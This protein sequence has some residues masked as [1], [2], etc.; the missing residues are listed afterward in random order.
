MTAINFCGSSAIAEFE[1]RKDQKKRGDHFVA[2]DKVTMSTLFDELI[3]ENER[4]GLTKGS[5]DHVK[6]V[7]NANLRPRW[8]NYKVSYFT[9]VDGM[10]ETQQWFDEQA[11]GEYD[12]AS[13]TL[14]GFRS[15]LNL[16]FGLARNKLKCI[17]HNPLND[18]PLTVHQKPKDGG[19]VLGLQD[20]SAFVSGAL[21]KHKEDRHL[22]TWRTRGLVGLFGLL[23]GMRNEE[24]AGLF[25][26]CLN[27]DDRE[28]YVRRIYREDEGILE[29]TKT[30]KSGYRTIPMSPILVP[31]ILSWKECLE[32]FGM[33]LEGPVLRT[34]QTKKFV[35][36][37][38]IGA[39]HWPVLAKKA[40][41][42]DVTGAHAFTYYDL[43][44][45]FATMLRTVGVDTDDLQQVMGHAD[46][47]TTVENYLHKSPH[48]FPGLK[49]QVEQVIRQLD[50]ERTAEGYIDALGFVLARRWKDE[51]IDEVRCAPPRSKV[52]ELAAGNIALL[53]EPVL[54]LASITETPAPSS[55]P[56]LPKTVQE[57]REIQKQEMCARL[58]EGWEID[59]VSK[60]YGVD[61][62]TVGFYY[63]NRGIPDPRGKLRQQLH[64][65]L[66]AKVLAYHDENPE[67]PDFEIGKLFGIHQRRAG[68][69]L[70][71]RKTPG[72]HVM[73][74]YKVGK[75]EPAIR[76]MRNEGVPIRKITDKLNV[77]LGVNERFTWSAVAFFC[78]KH[79]IKG[80]LHGGGVRPDLF[81][82]DYR[83]MAAE[84]KDCAEM[85]RELHARYP[86][87]KTPSHSGVARR[88]SKLGLRTAAEVRDSAARAR[89]K[90]KLQQQGLDADPATQS[91]TRG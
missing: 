77:G 79:K 45:T 50:L 58:D 39:N 20:I 86:N 13:G 28:I 51:G 29:T 1:K 54:D 85:A 7:I 65:E 10:Q 52:E 34:R 90:K 32:S 23:T 53:P 91:G 33:S 43:R 57:F 31:A 9:D 8:G 66:K 87:Q 26:D 67:T 14:R 16:T 5:Q 78:R 22:L 19:K 89:A 27:T 82:D 74:D 60:T 36:G 3:K 71:G 30:G 44:H 15:V 88:V 76:R 61:H 84:G 40:G 38:A 70:R 69:I 42:T 81:D 35:T 73:S 21:T 41:F 47:K 64:N 68:R 4:K 6:S 17:A 24:I 12:L 37:Q 63:R 11:K 59:R 55:V 49:R 48:L 2:G 62:N 75:F 56:A 46:Y 25:F 80:K 83:S 18:H 72:R